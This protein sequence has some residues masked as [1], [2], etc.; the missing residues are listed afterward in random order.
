[1]TERLEDSQIIEGDLEDNDEIAESAVC[2]YQGQEYSDGAIICIGGRDH[3]CRNGK[4]RALG[5][6][7]S[8]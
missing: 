5:T 8:C 2:H 7:S 6:S 1:M 4:W 3:K